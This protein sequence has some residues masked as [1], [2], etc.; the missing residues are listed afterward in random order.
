MSLLLFLPSS[1]DVSQQVPQLAKHLLREDFVLH[2][3]PAFLP[4]LPPSSGFLQQEGQLLGENGYALGSH[5][6]EQAS[7]VLHHNLRRTT[8]IS[9]KHLQRDIHM[10][11]DTEW[12]TIS[13][14]V[15]GRHIVVHENVIPQQG[16]IQGALNRVRGEAG[17][18]R[19]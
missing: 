19:S 16:Q 10:G 3:P 7:H 11:G 8:H 17:L 4:H 1:N 5:R 2:P 14:T 12:Q 15:N 18:L 9:A 13:G 6:V